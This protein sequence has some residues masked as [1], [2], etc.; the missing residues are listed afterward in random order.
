MEWLDNELN[1]HENYVYKTRA[2]KSIFLLPPLLILIGIIL[3]AIYLYVGIGFLIYCLIKYYGL[4]YVV[5]DT[6]MIVKKGFFNIRIKSI[7]VNIIYD[8]NIHQTIADKV[9][10]SGSVTIFS[11]SR[12]K[13]KLKGLSKP[14]EF[15]HALYSQ[16][17]TTETE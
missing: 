6:R 15:R 9:F 12:P 16:L 7:P 5:T 10:G 13:E 11:E 4:Q 3:N 17:P 14:Y 2:H 1:E 8:V